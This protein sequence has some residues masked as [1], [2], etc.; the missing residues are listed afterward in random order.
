MTNSF[1]PLVQDKTK[2]QNESIRT[3]VGKLD[4]KEVYIPD[5]QRDSEQW[6][7]RK[8][9]LFIESLLNNLT[10]PA[11]FFCEGEDLTDEVVDG[12]QP[13]STIWKFYKNDLTMSANSKVSYIAPQSILYSG[14]KFKDLDKKLQKIFLNYPLT[15]IYLPKDLKLETKLEIFRRINEGGTPLSG[16]DI[17]LAYYSESKSVTFI[18]LVGI[19]KNPTTINDEDSEDNEDRQKPFQRM[20][21]IAKKQGLYNPWDDF[22]N[23]REKWYEWWEKQKISKGQVPSLMFLWYLVCLDRKKL[24]DLLKDPSHLKIRF[25][26]STENAL[27]IYCAQL[28]YQDKN[29]NETLFVSSFDDIQNSYFEKFAKWMEMILS[30]KSLGITVNKYKQLALFIA[31][32]FELGISPEELSD[33]Q[34]NKTGDFIRSSRKFGKELLGGDN[35]PEPKGL[36]SGKSGQF[37]QCE[38]TV[39]IVRNIFQK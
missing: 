34:W 16:Q 31:G 38:V 12:Q 26:G 32:A 23:A 21:E 22:N 1:S 39:E 4:D 15:I 11:F 25:G 2:A 13:L 24:Y 29:Q 5:Y 8:Q 18:R 9:S 19:H 7:S 3:I 14:K 17:R 30:R 35:Y 28:K 27:D 20:V 6:D 37:R 33:E 10:I 36:W